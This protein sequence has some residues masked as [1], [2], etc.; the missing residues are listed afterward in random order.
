MAPHELTPERAIEIQHLLGSDIQMQLDECIALPPTRDEIERAMRLSLRWAER[1]K[2]PSAGASP[3][4]PCS[5]SCR[6]ATIRDCAC[7]RARPGRIGFDGYAIGGLAVGEPQAVMLAMVEVSR[8]G[9]AGRPA[10][11]SHG[12]RHAGGHRGGGGARHRHV[13]LRA[14]DPQRSTTPLVLR[15]WWSSLAARR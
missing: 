1:S 12:R 8:A 6:A 14:A 5:A 13:R 9:P 2:A 7:S 10:A 4:K 11:L 15:Q 3:A